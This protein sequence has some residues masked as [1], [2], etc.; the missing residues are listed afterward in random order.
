MPPPTPTSLP[1]HRVSS[2]AFIFLRF[3]FRLHCD[4]CR[5]PVVGTRSLGGT[6]L[7]R[8]I[9]PDVARCHRRRLSRLIGLRLQLLVIRW[10]RN[11]NG[12][13]SSTTYRTWKPDIFPSFLHS[14]P[15]LFVLFHFNFDATGSYLWVL[16]L[17]SFQPITERC[18]L[19][20]TRFIH[21]ATL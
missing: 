9:A 10:R 18:D 12:V 15:F 5:E 14:P 21:L 19:N 11:D 16:R 20:L 17:F 4:E 13:V 3:V 2:S 1:S 8:T 6:C 7:N